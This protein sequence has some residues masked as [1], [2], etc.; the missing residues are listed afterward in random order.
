M[1]ARYKR[2]PQQETAEPPSEDGAPTEQ[3]KKI[4]NDFTSRLQ[5]KFT[6]LLWVIGAG[7]L[8]TFTDVLGI[9]RDD[10]RVSRCNLISHV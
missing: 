6:A 8:F 9:I 2:V 5:I 1:T 4:A 10:P 3:T 7:C